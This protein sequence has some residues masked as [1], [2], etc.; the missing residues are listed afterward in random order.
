MITFLLHLEKISEPVG[1]EN[2]RHVDS[3]FA[4]IRSKT[5][6][7][8]NI[9]IYFQSSFQIRFSQNYLLG[10]DNTVVEILGGGGGSI[11]TRSVFSTLKSME[12]FN[13]GFS[14]YRVE[15]ASVNEARFVVLH[16]YFYDEEQDEGKKWVP[17]KKQIDVSGNF[18]NNPPIWK[19]FCSSVAWMMLPAP[20][21]S[22]AL[23]NAWVLKWYIPTAGFPKPMAMTM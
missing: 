18:L 2:F 14:S 8:T 20:K 11:G 5:W 1:L 15:I 17:T 16:K 7:V 12:I 4:Y 23:K 10:M 21:K 19:K 6:R 9:L 3:H 13:A 22:S